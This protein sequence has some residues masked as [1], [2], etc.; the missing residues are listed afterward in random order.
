MAESQILV[1]KRFQQHRCESVAVVVNNIVP[2]V[3]R[4]GVWSLSAL[5]LAMFVEGRC[6]TEAH[7]PSNTTAG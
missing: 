6:E 1:V 3:C 5:R 7:V 2:C 4:L